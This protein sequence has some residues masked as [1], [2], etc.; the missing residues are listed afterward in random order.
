MAKKSKPVPQTELS[1]TTILSRSLTYSGPLP[2]ASELGKYEQICQGAA[3]RI[4]GM[5]EKQSEHRQNIEAIVI[6]AASERSILGVKYAYRIALG[7]FVLSGLCFAF[8]HTVAGGTIFG[9]LSFRLYLCLY[10]VR[11]LINKSA[12][13]NGINPITTRNENKRS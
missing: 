5:A 11:V 1:K 7:A 4:I 12:R 8:D 9:K 3:D 6:K 2:T 13:R 10:T